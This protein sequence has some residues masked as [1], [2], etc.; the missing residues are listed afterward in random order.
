MFP[1]IIMTFHFLSIRPN[2][3]CYRTCRSIVQGNIDYDEDLDRRLSTEVE[4]VNSELA[5]DIFLEV[6]PRLYDEYWLNRH[7]VVRRKNGA[8]GVRD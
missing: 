8:V 2:Q 6:L 1:F 3:V 5:A 4:T 7:A